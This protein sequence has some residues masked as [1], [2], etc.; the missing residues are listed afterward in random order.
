[1][2]STYVEKLVTLINAVDDCWTVDRKVEQKG[3]LS[4]R[5]RLMKIFRSISMI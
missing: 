4:R 2:I 3:C 5:I 1:M